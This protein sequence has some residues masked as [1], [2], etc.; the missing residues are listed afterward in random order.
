MKRDDQMLL[1]L[2]PRRNWGGSRV[3]AGRKPSGSPRLPHTSRLP[4]AKQHPCHVTI[5]ARR[6]LRSFRTPGFVRTFEASLRELAA[7]RRDFRVIAYAVLH[8]HAHFVIE[9][10]DAHSLASG[11]KA[12]GARVARAA[13]RALR[14]SGSVLADR[15]H[16]T[17]LHTPKQVRHALAYV[18]LNARKHGIRFAVGRSTTALPDPCSSGRWFGGWRRPVHA[19]N[20]PPAVSSPRTWLAATGWR[21]WGLIDPREVPGAAG[22][23]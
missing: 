1:A 21:R 16:A 2:T 6:G 7:E 11:M 4:H 10:H 14:C 23:R 17:G 12:L 8:D 5:R 9:A 13:H 15:Y 18:L 3:G 22:R 19:G 20:D